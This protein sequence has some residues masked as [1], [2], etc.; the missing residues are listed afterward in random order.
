MKTGLLKTGRGSYGQMR[1]KSTGLDQMEGFTL[2]NRRGKSFQIGLL[3]LLS[4]MEEEIILWY[5]GVWVGMEW[6]SLWRFRGPW[7]HSNT[8]TFWMMGWWKALKSW[9]CQRRRGYSSR[10]MT[11]NTPPRRHNN[12]FKTMTFKSLNGLPNPLTLIPLN[13][14]GCMSKG[15]YTNTLHTLKVCMNFGTGWWKYG[16]GYQQKHAK[17]L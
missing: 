8:V 17:T 9:R 2:G 13:I 1:P 3:H 6:G 12:G 7:M 15:N 5:G 14:S 10:I 16:M 11:Q 4:S